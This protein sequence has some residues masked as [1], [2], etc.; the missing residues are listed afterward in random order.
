MGLSGSSLAVLGGVPPEQTEVEFRRWLVNPPLAELPSA[1]PVGFNVTLFDMLPWWAARRD[2]TSLAAFGARMRALMPEAGTDLRAWLSY[3][4]LS[5]DAYTALAKA[6]TARALERFSSLPDTLCPCAFDQIITA[7]LLAASGKN[8]EAAAVFEGQYPWWFSFALPLWRLERARANERI[9]NLSQAVQ[10]Y[11]YV[12]GVWRYADPEL[13]P[14]VKEAKEALAR[15]S[16][17]PRR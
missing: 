5:A 16:T 9:G 17:E 4:A 8:R 11:Q 3:G 7:Q 2:T 6:D 13:Q 10:D 12:A 15:L 1:R 14:Y